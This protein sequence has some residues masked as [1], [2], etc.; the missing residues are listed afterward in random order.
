MVVAPKWSAWVYFCLCVCVRIDIRVCFFDRGT[1][2][3]DMSRRCPLSVERIKLIF[4]SKD[5]HQNMCPVNSSIEDYASQWSAIYQKS[6]QLHHQ[7]WNFVP[8]KRSNIHIEIFTSEEND[9]DRLVNII[10]PAV[11]RVF[12]HDEFSDVLKLY[13]VLLYIDQEQVLAQM[14][15]LIWFWRL[16]NSLFKISFFVILNWNSY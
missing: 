9:I 10:D 1:S 15:F 12:S 4:L 8:Y 6:E 5:C 11:F 14:V 2:D 16:K 3:S 7:L 13:K